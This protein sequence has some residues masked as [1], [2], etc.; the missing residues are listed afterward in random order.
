MRM[1][2]LWASVVG[3]LFLGACSLFYLFTGMGEA[4]FGRAGTYTIYADFSSAS[5]LD[6][7]SEIEIAG[8]QVGQVTAVRLVGTRAQV[9]LNLRN[10]VQLQDDA[11]ASIQTK[12]LLGGRYLVITPGG[13]DRLIPPGGKLRE[14]ES[15]LD[16]PSLMAAYVSLRNKPSSPE[17]TSA[18]APK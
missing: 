11:I 9:T 10:D 15:P 7:G 18:A 13:S 17:S 6:P 14:T 2:G 3:F 12:G 4:V 8:V 16:L 1:A 5:G